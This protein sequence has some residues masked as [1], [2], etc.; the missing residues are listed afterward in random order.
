LKIATANIVELIDARVYL[1]E[2]RGHHVTVALKELLSTP[3]RG[4]LLL[5][6]EKLLR[7]EVDPRIEV[8]LEPKG[9]LNKLRLK[10]RGVKV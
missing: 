9:D 4:S 1:V 3:E 7:R 2:L 8:F 5:E 10:L 6:T